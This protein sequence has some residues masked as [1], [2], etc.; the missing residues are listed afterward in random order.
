MKTFF[1]QQDDTE[2]MEKGKI[3]KKHRRLWVSPYKRTRQTAEH[4]MKACKEWI[5]D[6]FE[7]PLFTSH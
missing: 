2:I 6:R 7:Q 5:T 3:T 1:K 4:I